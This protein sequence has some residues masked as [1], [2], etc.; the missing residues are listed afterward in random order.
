LGTGKIE[1]TVEILRARTVQNK[2]KPLDQ[3]R[4]VLRLKACVVQSKTRPRERSFYVEKP[5]GLTAAAQMVADKPRR[6]Y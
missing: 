3:T 2:P 5:A 4:D 6:A 1:L